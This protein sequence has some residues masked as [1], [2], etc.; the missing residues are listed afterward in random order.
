MKDVSLYENVPPQKNN[1]T[2]KFREYVKQ[3]ALLP[4]WHE[5]IELLFFTE[6]ECELT[7]GGERVHA[8]AGDLAVVNSTEVHSFEAT[9]TR[10]YCTLIYPEFFSDIDIKNLRLEKII[11]ADSFVAE[12]MSA[13][14]AEYEAGDVGGDMMLKSHTYALMAYLV[15]AHRVEPP[16]AEEQRRSTRELEL[17]ARVIE[18]IGA[19]CSSRLSTADLAAMCYFTESYFCRFFKRLTGKSTVD[20]INNLRVERAT[21]MLRDTDE[22]VALIAERVGFEDANYFSRTF[23]KIKGISPRE[24][25]EKCKMQNA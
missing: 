15:R 2:V 6:G 12:C 3:S 11:R 23:K 14:S 1:F 19:S 4:H 10:Y 25:R 21:V 20:Y 9:A 13:M 16:S 17:L 5:H 18:H 8:R 22:P 7:V 24:Y